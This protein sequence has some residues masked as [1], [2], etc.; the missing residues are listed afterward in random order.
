[1]RHFPDRTITS[2]QDL[3][4]TASCQTPKRIYAMKKS[5]TIANAANTDQTRALLPV[6][7]TGLAFILLT[8]LGVIGAAGV[9]MTMMM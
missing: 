1:M 2:S 4:Q 3:R 5:S 7:G 9:A 8:V 6:A